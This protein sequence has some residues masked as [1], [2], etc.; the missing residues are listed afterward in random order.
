MSSYVNSEGVAR[1]TFKG[2]EENTKV[3]GYNRENTSKLKP[4]TF[5]QRMFG[6]RKHNTSGLNNLVKRGK[7]NML[8]NEKTRK[9]NARVPKFKFEADKLFTANG[10]VSPNTGDT[11]QTRLKVFEQNF[12]K[13]IYGEYQSAVM[14]KVPIDLN[15]YALNLINE[16]DETKAIILYNELILLFILVSIDSLDYLADYIVSA[17]MWNKIKTSIPDVYDS[18]ETARNAI[19]TAS[20]V[21]LTGL[22]IG[23]CFSPATAAAFGGISILIS[24]ITGLSSV[25]LSAMIGPALGIR[26][27]DFILP[28]HEWRNIGHINLQRVSQTTN[29]RHEVFCA[30]NDIMFSPENRV[31]ITTVKDKLKYW[32]LL[33]TQVDYMFATGQMWEDK[34][35]DYTFVMNYLKDIFKLCERPNLDFTLAPN[36]PLTEDMLKATYAKP[37]LAGNPFANSSFPFPPPAVNPFANTPPPLPKPPTLPLKSMNGGVTRRRVHKRKCY[38]R[39]K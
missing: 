37:P 36:E 6:S 29:S 35:K 15:A 31:P 19:A 27:A 5:Y 18:E 9:E 26:F 8:R 1:G 32:G 3:V 25:G 30:I 2:T 38:T 20:T 34:N 39:R 13:R 24:S 16:Q 11:L 28:P 22:L 4:K 10:F 7:A 12:L 23:A 14:G 21:L 33:Q 17:K